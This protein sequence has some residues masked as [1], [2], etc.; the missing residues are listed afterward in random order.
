MIGY[1]IYGMVRPAFTPS[2]VTSTYPTFKAGVSSLA[3]R[4]LPPSHS[5]LYRIEVR[6]I[7]IE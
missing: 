1:D 5:G 3:N 2:L 7:G 6:E 4:H